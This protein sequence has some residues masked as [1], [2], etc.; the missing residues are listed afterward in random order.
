VLLETWS[1]GPT[2]TDE[3]AIMTGDIIMQSEWMELRGE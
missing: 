2:P 1:M 3:G